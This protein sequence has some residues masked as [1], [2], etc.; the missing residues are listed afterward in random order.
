MNDKKQKTIL[1]T[2]G[3]GFIGSHLCDRLIGMGDKVICVDSFF[4]GRKENIKHLLDNK[5]FTFIKHDIRR[6]LRLNGEKIERIYNLACPASPVQYQFDPMLTLET[7]ILGVGNMLQLARRLGSRFLQTSTSEVYGDPL[8]HPQK[9]IYYGNVNTLG[10]RACYDE[11]KRAAETLCKDYYI[12]HGVN[13]RIVR[14][15]NT[16]GPRMMFND[17]RVLSNFI[18]QA[19]LNE[20]ITVHG[21]G[22]QTRSFMYVDDLTRALVSVMEKDGLDYNPI[23]LGNPDERTIKNMAELVKTKT[24]SQSRLIYL[25]FESLHGRIGDPQRRCPDITRA[26]VLL[27]WDPAVNLEDGLKKTIED[28]RNRLKN[29]P[30]VL[31]F[32]TSYLP[33][34]GPAEEAVKNIIDRAQGWEFDIITAKF[35]SKLASKSHNGREHIYRLGFGNRWDKFLLPVRA[36]FFARKLSKKYDYQSAWAIMA[37]YGAFAAVIFS[38]LTRSRTPFLLSVYEGD[39][40]EKMTKRGMWLFWIY[41][42]IFRKACRWQVVGKIN[43]QQKAWLEEEKKAQTV[44][45]DGEWD[46]LAKRTK[47]MFQELEILSTRSQ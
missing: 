40:T 2:G 6:P 46:L 39:I 32:S 29:L 34:C 38:W 36:A 44:K 1:V 45:F 27:E 30:R 8:E 24:N 12:E 16:Y 5:N 33:I 21:D 9:E 15:F 22:E 43:E 17:G 4:S 35:D 47:E 26:K 14:I 3:A 7:N 20:D 19:L 42:I 25:P 18:L 13:A 11:G 28:F 31:V 41:K 10:E 23:N 37:S